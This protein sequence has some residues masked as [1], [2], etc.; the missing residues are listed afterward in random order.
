MFAVI[1]LIVHV[2]LSEL[3]VPVD[4]YVPDAVPYLHV[5]LFSPDCESLT[6]TGILIDFVV[7]VAVPSVKLGAAVSIFVIDKLAVSV[8]FVPSL[9]LAYTVVLLVT[10]TVPPLLIITK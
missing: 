6:V 8:V 7:V 10:F 1:P 2:L 5:T 4:P 9:N 3:I